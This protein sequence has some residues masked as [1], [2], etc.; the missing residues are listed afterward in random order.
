MEKEEED[1][2]ENM[3][4]IESQNRMSSNEYNKINEKMLKLGYIDGLNINPEGYIQDSFNK[5]LNFGYLEYF[6]KNSFKGKIKALKLI[7][8]N[9]KDFILKIEKFENKEDVNEFVSNK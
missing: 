1:I 5:G 3:N 7:Y 9:N 8:K 4:E 6:E 2:W